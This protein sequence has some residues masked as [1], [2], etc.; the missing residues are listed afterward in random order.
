MLVIPPVLSLAARL[1]NG[2]VDR[3]GQVML[4]VVAVAALA[5]FALLAFLARVGSMRRRTQA[6]IMYGRPLREAVVVEDVLLRGGSIIGIH[7]ARV[8]HVDSDASGRPRGRGATLVKVAGVVSV[9]QG[10]KSPRSIATFAAGHLR[11]ATLHS[12]A[13]GIHTIHYVALRFSTDE[14][15]TELS[16]ALLRGPLLQPQGEKALRRHVDEMWGTQLADRPD[17]R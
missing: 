5:F 14:V 6:T 10:V 15:H 1:A 3:G 17:V 8:S 7:S 13:S 4:L 16:Y 11:S 12:E 9:I 2:E